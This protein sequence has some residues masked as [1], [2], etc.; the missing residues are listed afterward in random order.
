MEKKFRILHFIGTVYKILAWIALVSS[1]LLA[2]GSLVAMLMGGGRVF[3]PQRYRDLV[4]GTLTGVVSF[5]VGL[6][7][8]VLYFFMLYGV[9]EGI[10]LFL[11][12][13]ENTRATARMLQSRQPARSVQATAPQTETPPPAV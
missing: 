9:G 8:A 10:F 1:I 3:I 4:P 11:A 2:I 5:L 6:V 13:E 12:I 7:M